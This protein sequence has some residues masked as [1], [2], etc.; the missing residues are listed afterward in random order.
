MNK[1]V[2]PAAIEAGMNYTGKDVES[3][4]TVVTSTG[5][6]RKAAKS[7]LSIFAGTVSR[8]TDARD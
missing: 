3:E 6:D 7:F 5:F 1:E 8:K 2:S 4:D